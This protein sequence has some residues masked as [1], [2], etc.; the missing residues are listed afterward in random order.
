MK[1]FHS[2][3]Q[4]FSLIELLIVMAVIGI[5]AALSIPWLIAAKHSARSASAIASLRLIHQCE[6]SYRESKGTYGDLSALGS[7][8]F[9]G[10]PDIASGKKQLYQFTV[11]LDST[12]PSL[13]YEAEAVPL[14]TPTSLLYHYYI[15]TTGVIR[16]K[17]GDRATSLD[18][19]I[20]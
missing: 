3:Q 20:D 8:R 14:S 7:A 10:D 18:D 11:T 19:P 12:D 16:R 4:G 15:N 9:L 17:L 13:Y 5:I 2:P 6:S 1:T